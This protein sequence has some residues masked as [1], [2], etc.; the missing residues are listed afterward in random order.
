METELCD[1][2]EI[3]PLFRTFLNYFI[4]NEESLK[5]S[6]RRCKRKQ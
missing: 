5:N 4:E 3:K 1:S 6:E 2:G